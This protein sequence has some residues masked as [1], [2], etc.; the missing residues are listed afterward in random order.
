MLFG[1]SKAVDSAVLRFLSQDR[2]KSKFPTEIY[3]FV[4]DNSRFTLKDVRKSIN[5][6]FRRGKLSIDSSYSPLKVTD[7]NGPRYEYKYIISAGKFRSVLSDIQ[8]LPP[9]SQ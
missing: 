5:R 2:N 6:L 1:K 4:G 7:S 3:D 8:E 9:K